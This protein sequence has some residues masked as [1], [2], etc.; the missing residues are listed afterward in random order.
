VIAAAL[1]FGMNWQPRDGIESGR[2]NSEAAE[3]RAP[4]R[5]PPMKI[6]SEVLVGAK[7]IFALPI[8]AKTVR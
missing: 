3:V 4:R 7:F 8:E 6:L 1:R 2:L 5:E